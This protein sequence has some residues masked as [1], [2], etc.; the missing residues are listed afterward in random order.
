[1]RSLLSLLS[2]G[3]FHSGEEVG[4]IL[5]ISRAA[6]WKQLHKLQQDTGLS[7][8]SVKGRGYR[9]L[10]GLEFLDCDLITTLLTDRAR[11]LLEGL[12]YSAQIDSTNARALTLAQAGL[13]H[14]VAVLAEQQT[15][16]RGRR[17]RSWTSPF[18]RNV[19]ASIGWEFEGGAAALE[20]L[21]LA[22]GVGIV[23]A[24]A[25]VGVSSLKLKWPNDVLW[26]GK[27]IAGVLIEMVGDASGRC[28]A[29]VGVGINVAMHR[30]FESQAI[31]QP[32]AD[33]ES[34][35][36]A[37][38]SRNAVVAAMLSELLPLLHEYH[39][40]GFREWMAEWQSLDAMAGR[41]VQVFTGEARRDGVAQGV[42]HQ[43]ALLVSID[44]STEPIYGGEVSL[45]LA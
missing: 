42:N 17:G 28:Q 12:E 38:V 41:S 29:V 44:G 33:A 3:A 32:W 16:G 10:G 14:G 30:A 19:Y 43:G 5:A 15:A 25:R 20:G 2:D 21:S 8:E 9:I 24:L 7:V 34:I 23:R 6:V 13:A 40:H 35:A 11:P 26:Q 27:K 31:D 39:I 4:A 45:R 1:M 36:G 37:H 22:V 18:G